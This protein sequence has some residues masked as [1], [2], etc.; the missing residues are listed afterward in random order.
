M[1]KA[2]EE[3][4]DYYTKK[5]LENT[6]YSGKNKKNQKIISCSQI[7]SEPQQVLLA[8][9]YGVIEQNDIGQNTIGTLVHKGLEHS[10]IKE[11][12]IHT[13]YSME[14]LLKNG[15][16]L[17]GTA[18]RIDLN[19]DVIVDTKV[20]KTY[21][22]DMIKKEPMH[23]YR[24]QLNG[25]RILAEYWYKKPFKMLLEIF[26][27]QGGYDVRSGETI[28]D[29]TYI[30]VEKIDDD[31]VLSNINDLI[32]FIENGVEQKCSDVWLRKVKGDIIPLRCLKYCSYNKVCK[33][34]N[35]QPKTII[36]GW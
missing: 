26:N 27:K 28:P 4:T 32:Q 19:N 9:K 2:V 18:D 13:E 17:S 8:Y 20:T 1:K 30:E 31:I 6:R 35:P 33:F 7:G 24:L 14:M 34:Y 29:L 5:I 21:T 11:A 10:F 12:N 15:W 22:I 25:L 36:K 3:V 23:Q 16:I